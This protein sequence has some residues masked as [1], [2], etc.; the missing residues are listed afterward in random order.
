MHVHIV[1]G[2]SACMT[3][4]CVNFCMEK[5]KKRNNRKKEKHIEF[6]CKQEV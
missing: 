4:F 2:I 6:G 5:E 3:A 1:L